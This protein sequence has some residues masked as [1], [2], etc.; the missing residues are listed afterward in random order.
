MWAKATFCIYK[1]KQFGN[2]C[3]SLNTNSRMH[4]ALKWPCFLNKGIK[5]HNNLVF[6]GNEVIHKVVHTQHQKPMF[7]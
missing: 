7:A 6:L 4:I 5:L 2:E 3:S 1:K